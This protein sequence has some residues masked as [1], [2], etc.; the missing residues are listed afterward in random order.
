MHD[1]FE[2][3]L[4]MVLSESP[5][6]Y[7]NL[8]TDRRL[9]TTRSVGCADAGRYGESMPLR[10]SDRLRASVHLYPIEGGPVITYGRAGDLRPVKRIFVGARLDCQLYRHAIG[11]TG[12]RFRYVARVVR[13]FRTTAKGWCII[14]TIPVVISCCRICNNFRR[15]LYMFPGKEDS[16]DVDRYRAASRGDRLR[17]LVVDRIDTGF[18]YLPGVVEPGAARPPAKEEDHGEAGR[19]YQK[20]CDAFHAVACSWC[21]IHF[22]RTS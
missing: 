15:F 3:F 2:S 18:D 20:R 9:N 16:R 21:S 12:R 1:H 5:K 11:R 8:H 10:P 6:Y 7:T 4:D 22:S 19:E 17:P 14:C 13:D